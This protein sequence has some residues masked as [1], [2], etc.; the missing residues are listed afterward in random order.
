MS[1]HLSL[2]MCWYMSV[3]YYGYVP[4]HVTDYVYVHSCGCHWAYLCVCSAFVSMSLVCICLCVCVLLLACLVQRACVCVCV[5]TSLC[6][7]VGVFVRVSSP[8]CCCVSVPPW[9]CH[10]RQLQGQPGTAPAPPSLLSFIIICH[11]REPRRMVINKGHLK[12]KT[13]TLTLGNISSVEQLVPPLSLWKG[14]PGAAHPCPASSG[15]LPP[16]VCPLPGPACSDLGGL[17]R[18]VEG[19]TGGAHWRPL[20]AGRGRPAVCLSWVLCGRLGIMGKRQWA[21]KRL[22][23]A[24][25]IQGPS[26]VEFPSNPCP[27]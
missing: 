8:M 4:G 6:T 19:S 11:E 14:V 24:W 25:K 21:R 5:R 13:T 27:Y 18:P 26:L 9:C 16:P 15:S 7:C 23:G 2:Y 17:W 10:L 22:R 1:R 12:Y 20:Q 3:H